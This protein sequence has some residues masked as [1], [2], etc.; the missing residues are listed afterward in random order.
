MAQQFNPKWVLRQISNP[1]LKEFFEQ[2]GYPLDVEW[3]S[4]SGMQVDG[5]FDAWQR[6][7]DGPRKAIEIILHDVHEMATEDGIRVIIE[8]G[9]Y[10]GEDLSILL[11]PM[12]SRHDKAMWTCMNRPAVWEAA[13]R[14][15][16]ADSLSSG[17]SWVKRGN[18][19]RVVPRTDA[20]ALEALQEAMSAFYRERQ[21]RGH[22][23]RVEHFPRGNDHDYYFVYLSDYADTYINFDDAGNFQRTPERRAFEVVFAYDRDAGTLETYAKGG[24]KAIQPLQRVFARVI[25]GE[26]IGSED[27]NERP[28]EFDRLLD[29]RFSFPTDP[30]DGIEE[31]SV[32]CLRLS[33]L[34]RRRGRITLEADPEKGRDHIYEMLEEDLNRKRLPKSIL[35]VTKATLNFK[36][37]GHRRS[38]SLTFNTAYPNSCDLKSKREDLRLLGEK[39]LKRWQ[40]D[41]A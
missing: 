40:I 9:R 23:C 37:N 25:L 10:H 20:E 21:G 24:K 30:E 17:R 28:Y 2:Q 15:A 29:S 4:I 11:E 12:E 7:A 31:V 19:P 8:E 13:V 35:H 27:P 39:Y 26:S 33:I 18:M 14:F 32:R 22:H 34:G 38:R 5:I 41:V 6:L 16:R 3:H 36:L 1:L